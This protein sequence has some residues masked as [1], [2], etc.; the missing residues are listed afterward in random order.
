MI[1]CAL[2]VRIGKIELLI[3]WFPEAVRTLPSCSAHQANLSRCL[4]CTGGYQ[5]DRFS[6]N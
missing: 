2:P 6:K 5:W 4:Q 3:V 1:Q